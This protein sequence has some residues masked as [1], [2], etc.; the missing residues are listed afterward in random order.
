[1]IVGPCQSIVL[2]SSEPSVEWLGLVITSLADEGIRK[3]DEYATHLAHFPGKRRFQVE[4]RPVPH[5]ASR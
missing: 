5:S 3:A 2:G 4:R 1:M